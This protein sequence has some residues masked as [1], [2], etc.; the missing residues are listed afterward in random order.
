[1][2][3]NIPLCLQELPWPSYSGTASGKRLYLTVYALSCPNNDTV[4]FIELE[5]PILGDSILI[6]LDIEAENMFHI[7]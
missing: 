1:M 7:F 4:N 2:K 6:Q 3:S 5:S